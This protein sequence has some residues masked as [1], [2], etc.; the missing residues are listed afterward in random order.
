MSKTAVIKIDIRKP[1]EKVILKAVAALQKGSLIVAPTETRYGLIAR[2]D[3]EE[4]L[5][6]IGQVKKRALTVPIALFVRDLESIS[7]FGR[8]MA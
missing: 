8:M 6:K 2:A 7:N 4:T 5:K 1:D 3:R